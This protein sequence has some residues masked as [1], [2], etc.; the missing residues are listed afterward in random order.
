[1]TSYRP[2]ACS[3]ILGPRV[4][5]Q[6]I[7]EKEYASSAGMKSPWRC[8][9]M[10]PDAGLKQKHLRMDFETSEIFWCQ[11]SPV[12]EH[13]MVKKIQIQSG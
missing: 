5:A 10:V 8:S 1:M 6:G 7:P 3:C 4:Q 9:E 13:V 2:L 12:V 11:S